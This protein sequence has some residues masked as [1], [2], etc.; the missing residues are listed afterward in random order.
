MNGVRILDTNDKLIKDT[1][2]IKCKHFFECKG[3]KRGIS[4]I[5]FVER[6]NSK[7]KNKAR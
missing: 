1:E 6:R 5:N 3:K 7:D 4:C 2:C